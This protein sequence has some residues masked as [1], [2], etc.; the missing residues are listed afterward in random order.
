MALAVAAEAAGFDS[1]WVTDHGTSEGRVGPP[2]L[3]AY[4]LLGAIAVRTSRLRLGALPLDGERRPPSMVAK[5]VTGVDVI[6]HGRGI[7]TIGRHDGDRRDEAMVDALKV[8]RA[9]LHDEV[10]TVSGPVY[11]IQDAFNRPQPVQVGGVPVVALLGADRPLPSA[12]PSLADAVLVVGGPDR[13]RAVRAS[14]FVGEVIGVAA[15]GDRVGSGR[16]GGR[17]APSLRR[18]GERLSRHRGNGRVGRPDLRARSVATRV[19]GGPLGPPTRP[20]S[21]DCITT[22]SAWTRYLTRTSPGRRMG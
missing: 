17:G 15:P 2:R 13:V 1:F 18:R 10:P 3:E 22:L 5:I 21:S 6:S 20:Q 7:L 19:V 12:T 8:G 14:G 4:S 9:M 16:H 11:S